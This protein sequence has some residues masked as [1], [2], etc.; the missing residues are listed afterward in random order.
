MTDRITRRLGRAGRQA[1]TLGL[2]GQGS[3]QWPGQG[4]DPV[5]IIEKAVRLGVTYLD[6]SNIYGPSQKHYGQAFRRLGLIPGTPNYD[7]Q[8]REEI[9]LATKT[10]IRTARRP[11][12]ERFH[13]DYSE[14]MFD[15][16]HVKTAADDIRRSLSLMFGDG[17]GGYPH[18][19]YLDCIQFH[20]LNTLDEVDMLFKGFNDPSPDQ[21]WMGA[22]A[23]M[24]DLRKGT[25]FHAPQYTR[26]RFQF[27]D[28]LE[29]NTKAGDHRY[30]VVAVDAE[31]TRAETAEMVAA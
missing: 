15:D 22:L 7:P 29:D 10:H 9:F 20:N 3:I 17:K 8:L 13:S 31:G 21:A 11:E 28:L 24:L 2:G 14:G 19:A 18:G 1:S 4:I 16:F 30:R 27:D 23:A 26:T 5:G 12:A 25:I 6:T